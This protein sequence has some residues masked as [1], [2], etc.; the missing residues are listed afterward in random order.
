[1]AGHVKLKYGQKPTNTE[2]FL[3]NSLL[4]DLNNF[5]DFGE[6]I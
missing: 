1:M 2:N 6:F 3:F 4:I 5:S